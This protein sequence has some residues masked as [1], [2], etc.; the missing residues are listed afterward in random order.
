MNID[1]ARKIAQREANAS[2]KA[3]TIRR[4]NPFG[5]S[6]TLREHDVRDVGCWWFVECIKPE[7]GASCE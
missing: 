6:V 3:I 2:S 5:N 7:G 1:Q 4:L